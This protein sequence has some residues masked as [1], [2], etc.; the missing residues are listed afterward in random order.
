MV[1]SCGHYPASQLEE[2]SVCREKELSSI[3]FGEEILPAAS[4]DFIKT[5]LFLI[6][7]L[8]NGMRALE[9]SRFALTVSQLGSTFRLSD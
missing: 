3:R 5:Y 2:H 8:A 4:S 1:L 6:N 9:L 7:Y